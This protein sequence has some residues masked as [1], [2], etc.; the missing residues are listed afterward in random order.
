[1][2]RVTETLTSHGTPVPDAD[3]F[4]TERDTWRRELA[5]DEGIRADAVALQVDAE[6][7]HYT[8]QR[9]WAGVPIIRLPD[10]IVVFQELV[11]EYRPQRIIETGIAR[12]GSLLLNAAMQRMAGIEPRVLGIDVAIFPHTRTMIDGHPLAE[13]VEMLESDSTVETAV[14]VAREFLG[15]AERALL[16]L[17]SNHTHAHVLAE[18]RALA[19]LLPVGSYVLVAD[20]IVEEFPQG[21]YKDRDWDRGDNPMTAVRAFVAERDDFELDRAWSRRALVTEFRDGML[22]RT[23]GA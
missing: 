10:D 8:Y 14:A 13:G 3:A 21:H 19:P 6:A 7:H 15:D 18:L 23:A 2:E 11:W 12:G 16:V 9:E 22:V 1:V 20:T 4:A 5:D 17:D